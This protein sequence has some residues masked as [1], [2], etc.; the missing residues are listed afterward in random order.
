MK[1]IT[2]KDFY[3]PSFVLFQEDDG[4]EKKIALEGEI[5]RCCSAGYSSRII[6][7][8]GMEA[9]GTEEIMLKLLEADIGHVCMSTLDEGLFR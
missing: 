5:H 1:G 9:A 4:F 7:S 8:P 6:F 2:E 3:S